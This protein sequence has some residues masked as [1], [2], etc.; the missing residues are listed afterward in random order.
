VHAVA[1]GWRDEVADFFQ[2]LWRQPAVT[3]ATLNGKAIR[4]LLIRTTKLMAA[5]MRIDPL[6]D[7]RGYLV[8]QAWIHDQKSGIS[9]AIIVK[10]VVDHRWP[11][12]AH[13][14]AAIQLELA[15]LQQLGIAADLV[16]V[17]LRSR[18]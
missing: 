2:P 4:G 13:L 5:L 6:F 11:H 17:L 12:A 16:D 14:G 1:L 15:G 18:C 3:A 9:R 10:R 7:R 8:E